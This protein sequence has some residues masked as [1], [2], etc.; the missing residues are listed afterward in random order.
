M[1]PYRCR[2]FDDANRV[3]KVEIRDCAD[4]MVA[5]RWADRVLHENARNNFVELW[6]DDRLV[7]R[8]ARRMPGPTAS[9]A[10]CRAARALL[11]WTQAKLALEA[12]VARKTIADFESGRAKLHGRTRRDITATLEE[13]GVEFVWENGECVRLTRPAKTA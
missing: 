7:E 4:D 10:Q 12:G 8:R 9:S 3:V 11:R 6:S 2:L 1:Q 5:K 13:A